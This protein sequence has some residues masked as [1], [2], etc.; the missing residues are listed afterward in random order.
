MLKIS[1]NFLTEFNQYAASMILGGKTPI[2]AGVYRFIEERG[3][4]IDDVI[5]LGEVDEIDLSMDADPESGELYIEK[6]DGVL[7][8]NDTCECP[9]AK[10]IRVGKS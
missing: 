4:F 8:V 9:P 5:Y 10:Y 2:Q 6:E 3:G 7:L 1:I